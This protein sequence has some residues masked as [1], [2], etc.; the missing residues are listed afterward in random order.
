[1]AAS[2]ALTA[3]LSFQEFFNFGGPGISV[4]FLWQQWRIVLTWH[5]L[6]YLVGCLL[7]VG[8]EWGRNRFRGVPNGL[9]VTL[10]VILFGILA[11]KCYV[12]TYYSTISQPYGGGMVPYVWLVIDADFFNPDY[13]SD[14]TIKASV[15]V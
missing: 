11:T 8:W 4:N 15:I 12:L 3:L 2:V 14:M 7:A 13:S 5:I 9:W 10:L 6:L 1:L